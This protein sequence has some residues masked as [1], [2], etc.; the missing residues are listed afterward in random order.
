MSICKYFHINL[1]ADPFEPFLGKS[2]YLFAEAY[3][4][5]GGEILQQIIKLGI[6]LI[7]WIQYKITGNKDVKRELKQK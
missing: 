3:I 6:D 5:I 4:F 1:L 2:H 7:K